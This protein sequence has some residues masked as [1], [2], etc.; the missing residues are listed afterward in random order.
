[1]DY[2][3]ASLRALNAQAQRALVNYA[4]LRSK[5]LSIVDDPRTISGGLIQAQFISETVQPWYRAE[6]AAYTAWSNPLPGITV[7][8]NHTATFY[9]GPN[10]ERAAV[11]VMKVTVTLATALNQLYDAVATTLTSCNRTGNSL[12]FKAAD[13]L[14]H[15]A[16]L[17]Y[18]GKAD[19]SAYQHLDDA[20]EAVAEQQQNA[21]E[22]ASRCPQ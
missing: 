12:D 6:E 16:Q 19:S 5:A 9:Q 13:L 20:V 21:P 2:P 14:E 3:A 8:L 7:G 18:A 1:V 22:R 15:E 10:A 4:G 17:A 11:L